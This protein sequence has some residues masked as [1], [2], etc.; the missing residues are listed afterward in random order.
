MLCDKAVHVKVGFKTY[1]KPWSWWKGKFHLL[2]LFNNDIKVGFLLSH[3]FLNPMQV[4]LPHVQLYDATGGRYPSEIVGT[5]YNRPLLPFR[6]RVDTLEG[7][8][9]HSFFKPA[10]MKASHSRNSCPERN[11][12]WTSHQNLFL[13]LLSS[14]L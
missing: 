2:Y 1:Y 9:T 5:G 14:I 4:I 11:W 12:I 13:L 8:T 10:C 3:Y 6:S 7:I